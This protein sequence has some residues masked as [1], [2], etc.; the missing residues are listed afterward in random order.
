MGYENFKVPNNFFLAR[1][2]LNGPL[3]LFPLLLL[4]GKLLDS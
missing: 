2:Y 3:G 4:G 1:G